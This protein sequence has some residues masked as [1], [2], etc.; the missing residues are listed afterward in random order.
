MLLDEQGLDGGLLDLNMLVESGSQL[1][2]LFQWKMLLAQ[3]SLQVQENINLTY[4]VNLLILQH[5]DK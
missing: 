4:G 2:T 3:V 5:Q 1:R